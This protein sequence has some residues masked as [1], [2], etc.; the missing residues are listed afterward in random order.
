MRQE[1][2]EKDTNIYRGTEHKQSSTEKRTSTCTAKHKQRERG[3][4]KWERKIH[5]YLGQRA[6]EQTGG[7]RR[8]KP[9]SWCRGDKEGRGVDRWLAEMRE[10]RRAGWRLGQRSG[11]VPRREAGLAGWRRGGG[12]A[13]AP[14]T[15]ICRHR[16]LQVRPALSLSLSP[17]RS[18]PTLAASISCRQC[19]S[20]GLRFPPAPSVSRAQPLSSRPPSYMAAAAWQRTPSGSLLP[21]ADAIRPQARRRRRLGTLARLG[22]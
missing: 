8:E 20:R 11:E 22:T 14:R 2:R 4:S 3:K 17:N 21:K 5:S 19:V 10:A 6:E 15:R 18:I 12:A 13:S 1:H 16:E 7:W 9:D